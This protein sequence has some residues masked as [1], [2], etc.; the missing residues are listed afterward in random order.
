MNSK[1]TAR[2]YLSISLM[3]LFIFFAAQQAIVNEDYVGAAV[4]G[5]LA[6]TCSEWAKKYWAFLRK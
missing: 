5:V 3:I 6:L 4:M 1:Q 2:K